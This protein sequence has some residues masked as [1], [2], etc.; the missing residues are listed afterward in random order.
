MKKKRGDSRKRRIAALKSAS[1]KGGES[2]P[3]MLARHRYR[4][5]EHRMIAVLMLIRDAK[6]M[7]GKLPGSVREAEN[8]LALSARAHAKDQVRELDRLWN[9]LRA[10]NKGQPPEREEWL[11][12]R[13]RLLEQLGIA[14]QQLRLETGEP[15]SPWL[16]LLKDFEQAVLAAA[17]HDDASWFKRQEKAVHNIG[18]HQT[19]GSDRARY[20][21]AVL[22]EL[23]YSA[24]GMTEQD[25]FDRLEKHKVG[26]HLFVEDCRF[27]SARRCRADIKRFA[28]R[29]GIKLPISR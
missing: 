29:N 10:K 22:C 27:S 14:D 17:L 3:D 28:D 26:N 13:D 23:R 6:R 1:K 2:V 4:H 5:R 7:T 21:V 9:E 20:E 18:F 19:H 15:L 11:P 24:K 12:A 25:I 16:R 8:T